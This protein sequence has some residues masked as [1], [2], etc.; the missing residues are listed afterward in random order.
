MKIYII[1]CVGDEIRYNNT[2]KQF[3]S[4][5]VK[6]D[7]EIIP[8]TM[9]SSQPCVGIMRSFKECIQ[10]AKGAKLNYCMILEDDFNCLSET[11]LHDFIAIWN[12]YS[13]NLKDNIF[14]AGVY[15][16]DVIPEFDNFKP[17][18]R[19]RNKISGLHAMIVPALLYDEIL[20]AEEPYNLD[21][22]LSEIAKL[23]INVCYPFLI[24]QNDGY[25]YN[26]K[27]K[28]NYNENIHLKYK[29][30]TDKNDTNSH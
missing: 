1:H 15:S 8:A 2:L 9:H 27:E 28:T 30:I 10:K 5:N 24:M 20:N 13:W 21:Y 11:A 12:F 22:Y 16:G 25:S 6:Y 4:Q 18:A 3:D 26:K 17:F 7:Y 19:V 23:K 29:L 14:L